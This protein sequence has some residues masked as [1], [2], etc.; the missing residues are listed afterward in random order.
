MATHYETEPKPERF[1]H[2]SDFPLGPPVAET[3]RRRFADW[4]WI[5]RMRGHVPN[6]PLPSLTPRP[7]SRPRSRGA[8]RP[9]RRVCARR[10]GTRAGPDDD[11]A[12]PEAASDR[13]R[14]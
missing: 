8:G 3:P 13:G 1:Q 10:V 12:P 9:R 11:P 7:Q 4:Y 5:R 6:R 14:P 2:D